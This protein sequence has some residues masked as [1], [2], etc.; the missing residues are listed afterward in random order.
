MDINDYKRAIGRYLARFAKQ[1]F[2]TM[3]LV[4]NALQAAHEQ[5]HDWLLVMLL[6]IY[7][8]AGDYQI[9]HELDLSCAEVAQNFDKGCEY[10]GDFFAKNK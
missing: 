4:E 2:P 7:A 5:G 9:S 3:M 8:A 10:L 1:A 6:H